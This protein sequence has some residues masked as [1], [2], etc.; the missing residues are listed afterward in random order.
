MQV[1]RRKFEHC[2]ELMIQETHLW[3]GILALYGRYVPSSV[4]DIR[5][6]ISWCLVH[7]ISLDVVWDYNRKWLEQDPSRTYRDVRTSHLH[8]GGNTRRRVDSLFIR[9]CGLK[10]R[11]NCRLLWW[12]SLAEKVKLLSW[13]L[14][15]LGWLG[16]CSLFATDRRWAFL[17]LFGCTDLHRGSVDGLDSGDQ[18]KRKS[19]KITANKSMQS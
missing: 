17:L 4:F 7:C 15:R 1:S 6:M 13:W 2:H 9:A 19:A 10:F 8:F 16:L 18:S 14:C 5:V 12:W 11:P 3:F